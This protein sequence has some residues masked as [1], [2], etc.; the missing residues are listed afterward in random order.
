MTANEAHMYRAGRAMF[1]V[2]FLSPLM[3]W[4]FSRRPTNLSLP[5]TILDW[6][7]KLADNPSN[8]NK[9]THD[10]MGLVFIY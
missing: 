1:V 2:H 9:I 4:Y 8:R 6:T 10:K 5:S 7:K 3:V